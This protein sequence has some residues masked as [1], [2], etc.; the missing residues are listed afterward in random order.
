MKFQSFEKF[1][2]LIRNSGMKG[3]GDNIAMNR[4][5]EEKLLATGITTHFFLKL[6]NDYAVY[7]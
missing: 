5:I 3:E 1:D 7:L 4:S 6:I 2:D